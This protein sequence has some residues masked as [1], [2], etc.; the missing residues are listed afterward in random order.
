MSP[1]INSVAS[2]GKSSCVLQKESASSHNALQSWD[3]MVESFHHH[4][5]REVRVNKVDEHAIIGESCEDQSMNTLK[6][7]SN[8]P[9]YLKYSTMGILEEQYKTDILILSGL[10]IYVYL[11]TSNCTLNVRRELLEQIF[12]IKARILEEDIIY[13]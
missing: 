5:I 8:R 10:S 9:K 11:T 1:R 13:D 4:G 6:R 2:G 3:W 7:C 12:D